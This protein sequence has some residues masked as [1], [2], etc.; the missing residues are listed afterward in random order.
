MGQQPNIE[1][2]ISDLPRPVPATAPPR[3]WR[4]SRPGELGSPEEVPWGGPFGTTGPDTGYALKLAGTRSLELGEGEHRH[5]VEAAIVAIAGAR[6]SFFGRAP[7]D[8]DVDS[9]LLLLGLDAEG[10]PEGFVAGLAAD[11]VRWLANL[12][13]DHARRRRLVAS[14]A[15]ETLAMSP[16][17][18][19]SHMADGRRLVDL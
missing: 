9:A 14:I 15:V 3:R 1:L 19:R 7:T 16:A 8:D 6:A 11:R 18:I 17:E 13:H 5:N 4:P 10:L 2:E 12:A